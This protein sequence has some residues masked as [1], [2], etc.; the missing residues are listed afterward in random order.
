[1]KTLKGKILIADDVEHVRRLLAEFL[2]LHGYEV[3]MVRD[4]KEA[5]EA[6]E[7][8]RSFSLIITDSGMPNMDGIDLV[9]HIRNL[10]INVPIIGMSCE[11][12]ENEFRRAGADHFLLKPFHLDT[13]QSILRMILN[14]QPLI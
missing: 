7:K 8:D 4:G 5:T 13:L 12:K 10:G 2:S 1:M 3:Y 9:I 11:N 6:L 14:E